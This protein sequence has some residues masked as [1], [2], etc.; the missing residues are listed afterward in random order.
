MVFKQVIRGNYFGGRTL[1]ATN[2]LKNVKRQVQREQGLLSKEG[3]TNKALRDSLATHRLGRRLSATSTAQRT[4]AA[5]AR[6]GQ[7]AAEGEAD[8]ASEPAE[9]A[10]LLSARSQRR[11]STA[12]GMTTP[13]GAKAV[14]AAAAGSASR[15]ATSRAMASTA[16][17]THPSATKPH[18]KAAAAVMLSTQSSIGAGLNKTGALLAPPEAD[19]LRTGEA[20]AKDIGSQRGGSPDATA[21][22]ATSE[23]VEID[24]ILQQQEGVDIKSLLSIIANSAEVEVWVID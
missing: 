18:G 2:N 20:W 7:K 16:L 12:M 21:E 6:A 11:A 8:A 14:G 19:A 24:T 13:V 4:E 5:S 9:A 22:A 1:I 10:V 17:S 23:F 3:V 15:L